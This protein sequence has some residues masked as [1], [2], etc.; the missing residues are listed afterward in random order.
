MIRDTS[1]AWAVLGLITLVTGLS[2]PHSSIPRGVEM[3]P[4]GRWKHSEMLA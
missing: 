4:P 2:V 1:R 3:I